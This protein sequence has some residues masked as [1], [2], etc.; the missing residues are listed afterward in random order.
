MK[1]AKSSP[2][3]FLSKKQ[4]WKLEV[5]I[6]RAFTIFSSVSLPYSSFGGDVLLCACNWFYSHCKGPRNHCSYRTILYTV[7]TAGRNFNFAFKV[8]MKKA[9]LYIASYRAYAIPAIM[10]KVL[11]AMTYVHICDRAFS[12]GLALV[13]YHSQNESAL[14]QE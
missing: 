14:F 11:C 12:T 10:E 6:L 7:L 4:L 3:I 5:S 13:R 9:G 1:D 8:V 2:A